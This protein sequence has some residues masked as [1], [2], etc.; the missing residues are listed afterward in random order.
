MKIKNISNTKSFP[1]L[2]NISAIKL[3]LA[4]VRLLPNRTHPYTTFYFTLTT[5]SLTKKSDTSTTYLTAATKDLPLRN[6]KFKQKKEKARPPFAVSFS[7][8]HRLRSHR[9]SAAP[10]AP[11]PPL[12]ADRYPLNL[13]LNFGGSLR[14]AVASSAC[15]C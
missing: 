5:T 13:L 9:S 14:L 2:K 3:T 15:R 11:P 6:E 7:Q 1:P 12:T 10:T 4:N 8:L